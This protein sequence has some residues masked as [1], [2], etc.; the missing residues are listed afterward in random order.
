MQIQ[1]FT[2]DENNFSF[3]RMREFTTYAVNSGK[4]RDTTFVHGVNECN[5]AQRTLGTNVRR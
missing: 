4:Y 3:I 5:E 2:N 1:R